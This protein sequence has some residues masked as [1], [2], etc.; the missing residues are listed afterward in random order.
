[1]VQA[2]Y[3]YDCFLQKRKVPYYITIACVRANIDSEIQYSILP[4]LNEILAYNRMKLKPNI[5]KRVETFTA[6]KLFQ[7]LIKQTEIQQQNT[8]N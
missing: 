3:H 6:S 7:K 8:K 5:I 2:T 1:M 4:L